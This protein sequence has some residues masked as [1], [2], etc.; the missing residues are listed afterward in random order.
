M[1]IPE[2]EF[3]IYSEE[4]PKVLLL[5]NGLCRAYG[6]LS[7]DGLLDQIKEKDKYPYD[8]R[9]YIMPM[10]L[11][12]V[13]LTNNSLAKRMKRITEESRNNDVN[14][15]NE[16]ISWDSFIKTTADM[17]ERIKEVIMQGFDYVLTTNYSYEIEASLLSRKALSKRQIEGMMNFHEVNNAQKKYLINTYNLVGLVPIWH[18][19]GE[20][21]KPHSMVIGSYYYGKIL[22]QCVER[23]DGRVIADTGKGKENSGKEYEFK[24]NKKNRKPQKIGSW[25]DAFVLGDV[26]IIGFGL[27]FSESDL[28]WLIEYKSNNSELC[29]KTVFY[30]PKSIR[31]DKCLIDTSVS[32]EKT[33]RYIDTV[34]CRNTL[35]TEAY[36]VE[37]KDCGVVIRDSSDYK[38]FYEKV[39]E[40]IK[41]LAK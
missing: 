19:H 33:Q 40:D 9:D 17:E 27:D 26:Y 3:K 34:Q 12:A 23:L 32:C 7:W 21:R 35:L 25:I 15:K 14:A 2:K 6:G 24:K 39:I 31:K 11:K 28:W 10:P 20:A 4:R 36:N 1:K 13:M 41:L 38:R 37:V 5:G 16:S 8:A 18:I 22:R 29:G 30:T